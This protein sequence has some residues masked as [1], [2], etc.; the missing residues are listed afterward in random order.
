MTYKEKI[1]KE[2]IDI[3][4]ITN[5]EG[6]IVVVDDVWKVDDAME[7]LERHSIV[8]IDTETKPSFAKGRVNNVCLV[9]IS[10]EETCYLFRLNKIGFPDRLKRFLES[11]FVKKIG[12]SLLDDLRGLKRLGQFNP[13]RFVDLQDFVEDYGILDKSLKKIS[14]IVLDS[15]ISKKQRL[16]NWESPTLTEPQLKYAATDAW[17]CLIIYNKLKTQKPS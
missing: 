6:R 12:L 4:P 9:Q 2:D 15:R 14:A 1:E 16:T 5:F 17:I 3:L 7:E 10:T 8:G 13:K 11:E